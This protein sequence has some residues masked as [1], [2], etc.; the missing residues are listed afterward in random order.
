MIFTIVTG[1]EPYKV[2]DL[3][4]AGEAYFEDKL[5]AYKYMAFL[6]NV[7]NHN[8]RLECR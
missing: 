7:L 2:I 5:K 3:D 8:Y 4:T 1:K 6:V